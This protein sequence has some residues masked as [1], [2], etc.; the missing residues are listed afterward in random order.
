MFE[1]R[2][3]IEW[4]AEKAA[5]AAGPG[6]VFVKRKDRAE[7]LSK[8]LT[9]RLGQP[10]PFVTS[11]VPQ[12][13]RDEYKDAMQ[14]GELPVAV[15]T[16]AWSTGVDIPC[17]RWLAYADSGRAPIWVIQAAGRGA[18][19]AEGKD[20]FDVYDLRCG[21]TA[22]RAEHLEAGGYCADDTA[23]VGQMARSR[24]PRPSRRRQ[25][26]QGCGGGGETVEGPVYR[27]WLI[28]TII[29]LSLW[30]TCRY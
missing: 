5:S 20:G 26:Q 14:E 7:S 6:I 18:R 2:E 16:T 15:A 17:L 21:D 13:K 23:A 1:D 25:Q 27:T 4:L 30:F 12:G 24:R 22:E 3:V 29:L 9:A 8:A 28:W 19:P 11:D 10:I